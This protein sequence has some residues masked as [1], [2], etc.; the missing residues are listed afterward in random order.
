MECTKGRRQTRGGINKMGRLITII[1][2]CAASFI[3]NSCSQKSVKIRS[4]K[5]KF[6]D[7]VKLSYTPVK[8]QG[9]SSLCWA[10][11]M[12]A[13]IETEHIMR[14]DSVNL[15]PAYVARMMLKEQVDKCYM[16]QGR[17]AMNMRGVMPELVRLIQAY[18][19]MPYE[20]YHTKNNLS[21]T[22][23]KLQTAIKAKAIQGKGI[24][25]ARRYADD[26]LDKGINPMPKRVY[27]YSMEYSPIEFAHSVCMPEEY[28]PLTSFTHMPMNKKVMFNLPDNHHEAKFYNVT[29][30]DMMATMER[31]LRTGHPV[32]WEGDISEPGFSFASGIADVPQSQRGARPE[33]RQRQFETFRT[34]D[35]HCMA[36]IGIAHDKSGRKF[37]ICKNSWGNGNPYGGLMY[38]SFDYARLKTIA[39]MINSIVL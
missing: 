17:M 23:R 24:K 36:I 29:L 31:S 6:T 7:E 10:Y 37:F 39:V 8:N 14:G 13:T 3:I 21:V 32:C 30:N 2:I 11:A 28:L 34:T 12:L 9:R 18:G 5:S 4:R 35:D 16:S 15:S 1:T 38:M 33:M 25:E 19:L 22:A 26:I 27:M 20:S